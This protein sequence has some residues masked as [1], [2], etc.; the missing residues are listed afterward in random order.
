[1]V[2]P[3]V[4]LRLAGVTALLAAYAAHAKDT[5]AGTYS[6]SGIA[7]AGGELTLRGDGTYSWAVSANGVNR[8]S[9]GRWTRANA[10]LSLTPDD[11]DNPSGIARPP[12]PMPWSDDA[13][14]QYL[15]TVFESGWAETVTRCPLLRIRYPAFVPPPADASHNWR[16]EAGGAARRAAM[17]R[18]AALAATEQWSRAREGSVEWDARLKSATDALLA[19]ENASSASEDAHSR[20]GLPAPV[21]ELIDLPEKCRLPRPLPSYEPLPKARHPQ[22]G[23]VIGNP[24]MA[25][26]YVGARISIR[27]SDGSK[28]DAESGPGGWVLLPVQP[29]KSVSAIGVSIDLEQTDRFTVPA[30]LSGGGVLIVDVNPQAFEVR[31]LEPQSLTLQPDGSLRAGPG[32]GSYV[33]L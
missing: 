1:M 24:E 13:E 33:K 4:L 18:R 19:Y 29:G 28:V 20:A 7:E 21:E 9:S 3:R 2:H 25:S 8:S 32:E 31:A 14:R 22:I 10:S 27:F 6:L 26:A 15:R 30:Q 5:V 12:Q 16:T 11:P 17:L 23:I